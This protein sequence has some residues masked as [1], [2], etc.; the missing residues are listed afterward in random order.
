MTHIEKYCKERGIEISKFLEMSR[1]RNGI[2]IMSKRFGCPKDVK[3]TPSQC[4][5]W[6]NMHRSCEDCWMQEVNNEAQ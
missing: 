1:T 6:W 5:T 2:Y 4:V 3:N